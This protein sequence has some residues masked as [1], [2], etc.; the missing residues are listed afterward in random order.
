MDVILIVS[1]MLKLGF[2]AVGLYALVLGLRWFDRRAGLEFKAKIVPMLESNPL[3][4]AIYFAGRFLALCI[5]LGALIGCSEPAKTPEASSGGS[6]PL[7]VQ[8][9]PPPPAAAVVLP[10]KFATRY[11]AAMKAS[12]EAYLPGVPWKLWA[13]QVWQESRFD[14]KA[15]SPVGAEGLAQFMPGTWNEVTKAMG[16]GLVDRT[17]AEVSLQAG[18]FYMAR[19]RAVWKAPR[20]E[21]DRHD[22]AMASYNAGAGNIIKAQKACAGPQD[23]SGPPGYAAIMACLPQVTGPHARET[24]GYAPAIRKWWAMMEAG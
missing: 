9:L 11:A 17:T 10:G 13:G 19:Q 16:L 22:L 8:P 20:P 7:A 15:R 12:A 14:P 24:L 18:A 1:T 4:A 23:P 6:S 21:V 2:A 3:A 5:L